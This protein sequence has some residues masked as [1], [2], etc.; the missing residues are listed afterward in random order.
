MLAAIPSPYKHEG[1][2]SVTKVTQV[3]RGTISFTGCG[4]AWGLIGASAPWFRETSFRCSTS[5]FSA[6]R[7]QS[8]GCVCVDGR[9]FAHIMV[10]QP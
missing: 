2:T 7:P 3:A 10:R 9:H 8:S 5:L 6:L 1:R 4:V